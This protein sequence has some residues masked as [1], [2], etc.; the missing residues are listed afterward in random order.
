MFLKH[1]DK[2]RTI[3]KRNGLIFDKFSRVI[4]KVAPWDKE[5]F[6]CHLA[7][8]W[9]IFDWTSLGSSK[10]PLAY[11]PALLRMGRKQAFLLW[12]KGKWVPLPVTIAIPLVNGPTGTIANSGDFAVLGGDIK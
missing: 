7:C 3:Y 11:T 12:G 10:T 5:A 2:I 4:A 1:V 9:A 8:C 6:S